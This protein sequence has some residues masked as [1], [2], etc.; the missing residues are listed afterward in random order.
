MPDIT[1]N[2]SA[3]KYR[4]YEQILRVLWAATVPLFRLT[5]RP[6]WAVRRVHLRLFGA[7]VGR[8]ARIYPSAVI[9]MPWNITFGDQCTVGW[10]VKLYALGPMQ[11]GARA[12]ISQY[13]HLCGGTHDLSFAER[14]LVKARVSIGNGAWVAAEAFVGPGVTVGERA[15]VGARAVTLKDV[16]EGVVV[17]GNPAQII[18]RNATEGTAPSTLNELDVRARS[19]LPGDASVEFFRD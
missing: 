3:R 13:A 4:V 11:I 10:G 7:Q 12:T 5:P 9:F 19:V 2:R 6:L 8:G 1:A 18:R 16:S 17:S 14:P 15:V